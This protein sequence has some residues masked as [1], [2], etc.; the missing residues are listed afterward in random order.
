VRGLIATTS[1][2]LVTVAGSAAAESVEQWLV[3]MDHA[4]ASISY[5]GTLIS[6][7]NDRIDTLRVL[8]RVDEDGVRERIYALDGPPREV[9][10]DGDQVRCLISGQTSLVVNNPFPTRLFPRIPLD[11]ILGE[12][13]VYT[14][15]LGGHGRVASRDAR[16]IEIT[17]NDKYRYGRTLW[18]D[19]DTGMLL[20]SMVFDTEGEVVEK[21]SFVEIELG[22]S[23][24]DAELES[25]LDNAS[26]FARYRDTASIGEST[27]GGSR[28]EW[29]PRNLPAGFRLASVGSGTEG[30]PF[31]HLLFSDGLSSFSIYIEPGDDAVFAEHVEARGATHIY[32]GRV[33]DRIVTVVG[34]VP[35]PTVSRVGHHFL[36]L[37]HPALRH[38]E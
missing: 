14:L 10:R 31:E 27:F 37:R 18:L 6:T 4:I 32:T 26:G 3:R 9:L 36:L 8:H 35:A 30:N 5:R 7:G 16:I 28:P 34:E 12:N 11:A 25:D 23:I 1:L 21:M 24:R 29:V 20:R 17:P 13:S 33:K 19:A 15:S 2:L 38:L 22:A